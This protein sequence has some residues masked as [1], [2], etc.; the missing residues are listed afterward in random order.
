MMLFVLLWAAIMTAGAMLRGILQPSVSL[1]TPQDIVAFR[2]SVGLPLSW[3][4]LGGTVLILR[5]RG[6]RLADIGWGRRGAI[7]GWIL[8]A[9]LVAVFTA[10]SFHGPFLDARRWLSDWSAFRI[11]TAVAIGFTAG[12]CEETMFRGFVM[13]QA[14]AG[15]APV[16]MQILLSGVLFGA[17]HFGIGG[18]SGHFD[19]AGAAGASISTTIFGCLFALVYLAAR[20]SLMPGIAGHGLFAFISEPWTLLFVIASAR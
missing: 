9:G 11:V 8:A 17:A 1:K 12:I 16:W 13:S 19:L 20:R 3:L 4:A 18:M 6:L 10:G 14:K 7:W 5:L 15:G 2:M